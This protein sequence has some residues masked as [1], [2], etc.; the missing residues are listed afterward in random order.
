[1]EEECTIPLRSHYKSSIG[2]AIT[3]SVM[4][5]KKGNTPWIGLFNS[6]IDY[7]Y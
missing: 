2:L 7:W 5:S 1:M 6:Q 3:D 4:A